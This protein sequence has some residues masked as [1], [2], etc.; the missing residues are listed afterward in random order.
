MSPTVLPFKRRRQQIHTTGQTENVKPLDF[1]VFGLVAQYGWKLVDSPG[2]E[3][4][5]SAYEA[6]IMTF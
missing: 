3:P 5:R 1:S 4:G 2:L 6:H